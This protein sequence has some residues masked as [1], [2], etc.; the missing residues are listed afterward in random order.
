MAAR[1]YSKLE[2][3]CVDYQIVVPTMKGAIICICAGWIRLCTYNVTSN[4]RDPLQHIIFTPTSNKKRDNLLSKIQFLRQECVPG[5]R[6]IRYMF[7]M[8]GP[9]ME[10]TLVTRRKGQLG[11]IIINAHIWRNE[12]YVKFKVLQF[13]DLVLY[14][15]EELTDTM[16][17][18][19]TIHMCLHVVLMMSLLI[20]FYARIW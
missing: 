13:V 4:T 15:P 17:P 20:I 1:N 8:F 11:W 18:L 7:D 10:G 6:Y 3:I 19:S 9:R 14:C 2:H 12:G 5:H 16:M